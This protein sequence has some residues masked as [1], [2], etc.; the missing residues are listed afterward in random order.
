[1]SL[2]STGSISLDSTFNVKLFKSLLTPNSHSVV[3]D[4][5]QSTDLDLWTKIVKKETTF[6]SVIE[7]ALP[8]LPFINTLKNG[9]PFSWSL[10]ISVLNVA[11]KG[12]VYES[13]QG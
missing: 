7:M 4:F 1:M 5:E 2:I 8:H 3:H 6:F 9:C 11:D 13:Q 12:F 10:S